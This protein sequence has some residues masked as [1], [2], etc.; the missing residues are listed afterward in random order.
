MSEVKGFF[1]SSLVPEGDALVIEGFDLG[2]ATGRYLAVHPDD[3]SRVP[4]GV[5]EKFLFDLPDETEERALRRL[6]RW[7]VRPPR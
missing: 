1:A 6:R 5:R 2:I 7:V 3:W 4:A